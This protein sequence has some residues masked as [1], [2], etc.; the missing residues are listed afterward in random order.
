MFTLT[1][2]SL[3]FQNLN[4]SV[5]GDVLLSHMKVVDVKEDNFT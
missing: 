5:K 2:I 1:N 3:F 4:R